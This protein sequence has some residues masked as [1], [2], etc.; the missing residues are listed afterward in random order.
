MTITGTQKFGLVM[1]V[2]PPINF[3]ASVVKF[4]YYRSQEAES[5]NTVAARLKVSSTA[6]ST[7]QAAQNTFQNIEKDITNL[8]W[9]ALLQII[10]LVGVIFANF[11]YELLERIHNAFNGNVVS[12][13]LENPAPPVEQR[14]EE[15]PV[16]KKPVKQHNE[17]PPA[18]AKPVIELTPATFEEA[19]RKGKV[20]VL[21]YSS[22]T[23]IK[24]KTAFQE[25]SSHPRMESVNFAW[26]DRESCN[27]NDLPE[28]IKKT[29]A[30]SPSLLNYNQ[31]KLEGQV[32]HG[33]GTF[34]ANL[35]HKHEIIRTIQNSLH[36]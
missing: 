4:I 26:L 15:P 1:G 22:S 14:N 3:I 13:N 6:Q 34:N 32:E 31:G 18:A 35:S 21:L 7:D 20:A 29:S 8:K 33:I 27:P 10:P 17:E 16:A 30:L 23:D 28:S 24:Y 5:I 12:N 11:E 25:A 36:V 2:I 19:T 9:F